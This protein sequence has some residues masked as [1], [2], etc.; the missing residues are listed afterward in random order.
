MHIIFVLCDGWN[1]GALVKRTRAL[2]ICFPVSDHT[3]V[4][5]GRMGVT[6]TT[7]ATL[8]SR[9]TFLDSSCI[10]IDLL[11]TQTADASAV[12]LL[13]GGGISS[14]RPRREPRRRG[15]DVDAVSWRHRRGTTP[16]R[17]YTCDAS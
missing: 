5:D 12:E 3:Y 6:G 4:I 10:S 8:S 14:Q 16:S 11:L 17:P 13:L 2:R 9:P 7:A 15:D 1:M